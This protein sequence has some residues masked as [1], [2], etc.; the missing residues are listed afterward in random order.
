MVGSAVALQHEGHPHATPEPRKVVC[1]PSESARH[2]H[3]R[4][5]LSSEWGANGHACAWAASG[6]LRC[7]RHRRTGVKLVPT[8][9]LAAIF[10]GADEEQGANTDAGRANTTCSSQ[11]GAER[12]SQ[13]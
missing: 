8:M 2:I 7:E 9:P 5:Q 4:G 1:L 12:G 6:Q 3:D 10:P 13:T 11:T